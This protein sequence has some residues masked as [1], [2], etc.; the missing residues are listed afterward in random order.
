MSWNRDEWQGRSEKKVR[1]MEK[2]MDIIYTS[3]FIL[4]IGYLIYTAF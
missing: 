2:M 3:F 4:L 1:E